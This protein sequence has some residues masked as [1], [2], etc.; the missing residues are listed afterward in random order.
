LALLF[1][2]AIGA[3][4]LVGAAT[5]NSDNVAAQIRAETAAEVARTEN[6]LAL[7]EQ[8]HRHFLENVPVILVIAGG[9]V[10]VGLVG[11]MI[12]R[13]V[14]ADNYRREVAARQA[15]QLPPPVIIVNQLPG[16]SRADAWRDVEHLALQ[17][18]R[19]GEVTIWHE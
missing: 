14:E 17:S 15:P 5:S 3:V 16:Q 18:G 2:I 4:L 11:V 13:T 12:W 1:I 6:R 7:A 9:L 19:Q 8:A 10:L